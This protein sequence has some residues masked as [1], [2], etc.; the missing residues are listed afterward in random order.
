MLNIFIFGGGGEVE[1]IF[2]MLEFSMQ[3]YLLFFKDIIFLSYK[4][5]GKNRDFSI[6]F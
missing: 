3:T 6:L 4:E 1:V 5:L 2:G